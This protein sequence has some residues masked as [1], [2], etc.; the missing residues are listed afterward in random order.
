MKSNEFAGATLGEAVRNA[1][2]A[3]RGKSLCEMKNQRR[4]NDLLLEM[5]HLSR[6]ATLY[7][8]EADRLRAEADSLR[9]EARNAGLIAIASL[10][11][12]LAAGLLK[13]RR[14]ARALGQMREGDL[15][16]KT[17]LEF[18]Q[19]FGAVGAA[20]EGIQF[21]EKL[22][23][24]ERLASKA[25]DLSERAERTG[26]SYLDTFNKFDRLGCG[27]KPRFTGF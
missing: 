4:C 15:S 27:E 12:G 1:T 9:R 10:L 22:R 8:D 21:V 17:I 18:L 20:A 16:R 3:Y 24:A 23:G 25:K 19:I 2:A 6:E 26:E 7:E 14:V 13:T 11:G 5:N